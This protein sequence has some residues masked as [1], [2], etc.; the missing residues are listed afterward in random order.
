MRVLAVDD[1]GLARMS[2]RG[3]VTALG[4]ECLLAENGDDAWRLLQSEEID[5][6]ITD[7]MMPDVDGLELCR[8]IREMPTPSSYVYVVL[9][10]GLGADEE[11]RDGMLAGADDYL[12][13]PLRRAQLERKLIAADRVT[14]LQRQLETANGKL[15]VAN[16][17]QAD[18]IAMLG[19]DARQ[20]LTAVLG[21]NEA[22]LEEW[23]TSALRM[24]RELVV[25]AA[26]AA[27]RLNGL[28]EDVLTMAN[29][30]SGTLTCRTEIIDVE[31]MIA[32][33]ATAGID[34]IPVTITA[35]GPGKARFD[36]WHF[37]QI[38]ANLLGNARK[39]GVPPVVV[40]VHQVGARLKIEVGDHGEGVPPAFVPHL[41]ERFSRADTGIATSK[42]GTGF[43][44]YIVHQLA[45]ANHGS[46]TYTPRAGGGSCF[47]LDA[48][49]G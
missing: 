44:L 24:K 10:S 27:R 48:P 1:D 18:M 5:V 26:K 13:K 38:I 39:Y 29:L 46:V 23:D 15:A 47:T 6:V 8:R 25:K 49:A 20:P 16:Q 19:H 42:K 35:D 7:R 41:F 34:D 4:H 12:V 11:A 9:A 36:P 31:N 32:E 28:I 43:G 40:T 2:M 37:R 33:I 30:D 45:E 3:M 14:T 21:Y 22:N 17:L